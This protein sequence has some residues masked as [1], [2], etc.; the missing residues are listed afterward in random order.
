[1]SQMQDLQSRLNAA[2]D[3]KLVKFVDECFSHLNK[4]GID[5]VQTEYRRASN[6][7]SRFAEV[8][9]GLKNLARQTLQEKFRDEETKAFIDRVTHLANSVDELREYVGE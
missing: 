5:S 8:V 9:Y 3:A 2:A 7:S 1:M 6:P 4:L